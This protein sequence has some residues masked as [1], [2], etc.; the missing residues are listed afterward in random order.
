MVDF[1]EIDFPKFQQKITP[2]N[3][4]NLSILELGSSLQR[5]DCSSL[6]DTEQAAL[7]LFKRIS[8]ICLSDDI[9]SPFVPLLHFADGNRTCIPEDIT[10]DEMDFFIMILDYVSNNMLKAR[11]ADIL[12]VRKYKKKGI[13]YPEMV[14]EK[15]LPST[16]D[17]NAP[18]FFANLRCW[19][20]GLS[21]AKQ[22]NKEE[23]L[24][25]FGRNVL[26]YLSQ[27]KFERDDYAFELIKLLRLFGLC[28][29]QKDEIIKKAVEWGD[30]LKNVD[31]FL[32]CLYYDEA[33]L[34]A[35]SQ[36]Q[37][38]DYVKLQIKCVETYAQEAEK[39]E[40]GN[41]AAIYYETAFKILRDLN[42]EKR[43][44]YFS[45]EQENELI[46]NIK[47]SGKQS[48]SEMKEHDFTFDVSELVKYVIDN[49]KG[50]N[51]GLAL[52]NFTTLFGRISFKK[53][54][55]NAIDLIRAFPLLS[56]LGHTIYASDGR[57]VARTP[58]FN[59]FNDL[60]W[61]NPAVWQSMVW[62]YGNRIYVLVQIAILPALQIIRCEHDI[63]LNDIIRIVRKSN[64]IPT[65]RVE[66][67]A[68]GLYAGFSYDFIT[69]LN[70]LV[71]QIEHM[72]RYHLQ[73]AWVKTSVIE[74]GIEQ[75]TG[76]STLIDK[77]KT[78]EIFC[79]FLWFEIKALFCDG[80]GPN[81]RNN[82]AHGLLSSDEMKGLYSIYCWWFCFKLVYIGF[83]NTERNEDKK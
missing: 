1:S 48:L 44:Q 13:V 23:S 57:V 11:I 36:K 38:D 47:L 60:S 17:F 62:Q 39:S 3:D 27:T 53:L 31:C 51:S 16:I 43:L 32:A 10:S 45:V 76:L 77:E 73:E 75:E 63:Q 49:I 55:K 37:S 7:D 64:L 58:G 70:L 56:S 74:K 21:V 41:M 59:D 72:V 4:E 14:V 81:L 42:K 46:R 20:R 9:K 83:Y 79:L 35:D 67:F 5:Y 50:Q 15:Y 6:T 2:L 78:K 30:K 28:A 25:C 80:A 82:V 71:P 54:E 65:D 61:K 33:S 26:N 40:S 8:S 69:A 52:K 29:E 12:W 22:I 24:E 19:R 66:V 18:N 34:W 68:K